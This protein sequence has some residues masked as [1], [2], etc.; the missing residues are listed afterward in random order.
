MGKTLYTG[1]TCK[2]TEYIHTPLIEIVPM[3]DNSK[4]REAVEN[5]QDDD[6]LLFTS[7]FTAVYW[8][9][10]MTEVGMEWGNQQIVSIGNTTTHTLQELG[11]S[12]ILQAKTDDSY[13]VI[14]TF[15]QI[16]T[17]HRIFFP[18]S[19]IA[20]NIIPD[21]LRKLGFHV[22][23]IAAYRNIMPENAEKVDLEDIDTIIFTSPSTIDNFIKLYGYLPENK[24]YKTRGPITERHL[25]EKLSKYEKI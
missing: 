3:E 1:I 15:K 9:K 4:I 7:R 24:Q 23:T 17:T 6:I 2:N 10:I 13:G 18:R 12:N 16:D 8:H 19:N 11:A 22:R 21:G 25:Q 20:L 14:E 5:L